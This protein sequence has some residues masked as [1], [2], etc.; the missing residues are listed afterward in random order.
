MCINHYKVVRA[1][2]CMVK[3]SKSEHLDG[4]AVVTCMRACVFV[5]GGQGGDFLIF[6]LFIYLFIKLY[7]MV[8]IV[9]MGLFCLHV[10][11]SWT[12]T[13]LCTFYLKKKIWMK[14]KIIC[15]WIR[16]AIQM[17]WTSV[18][19]W[20]CVHPVTFWLIPVC[21]NSRV[22]TGHILL[23]N[24]HTRKDVITEC[25]HTRCVSIYL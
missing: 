21:D 7:H 9:D 2:P 3:N 4:Y 6:Y 12:M 15:S 24:L 11:V 23:E 22:H 20:R 5:G 10:W 25:M 14:D 19:C 8:E 16:S 17:T 18:C 1:D 13:V